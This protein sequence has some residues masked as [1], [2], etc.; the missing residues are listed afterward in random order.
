M[1]P[2]LRTPIVLGINANPADHSQ[3]V[4]D[5]LRC[6]GQNTGN[7]LFSKATF[8]LFDNSAR[9]IPYGAFKPDRLESSDCI[10][11]AGA[12]WLN[13]NA[14]FG[15]LSEKLEAANLPIIV[16]GLGAQSGLSKSIPKLKPGTQRLVSLL[17]ERSPLIS[18]RGTFSCEVL[19]HY[20]AKNAVATGCPSLLMSR[21]M[22]PTF[23]NQAADGPLNAQDIVIHSTRHHFNEADAFHTY[24]YRQALLNRHD[25][26]LQSELADFYP[27]LGRSDDTA[28]AEKTRVCLEQV[29]E[30]KATEVEKY[31]KAH[32]HVYF[33]LDEWFD[34]C[35]QKRFFLGTRIHGTIAAILSGTP[36]LLIAHDSRTVELAEAMGV[37]YVLKGT[38]DIHQ[39]LRAE[40][41]YEQAMAHDFTDSYRRY[42][43]VFK[44]FFEA[45]RLHTNLFE[46]QLSSDQKDALSARN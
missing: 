28:T 32:G 39:P 30:A 19:E 7:I 33:N 10:V 12:N 34:Y 23:R 46:T 17:A 1:A 43:S 8:G 15:A 35:R 13:Q 21:D 38:V 2:E 36:S 41:Y 9:K 26:L 31:L 45:C 24:L 22:V 44:E 6:T 20:G 25:L 16:L 4:A 42:L 11:M 27:V 40:A 5:M 14:D 37:P 3:S 29:Y 18:A